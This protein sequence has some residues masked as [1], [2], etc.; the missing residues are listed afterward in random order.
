MGPRWIFTPLTPNGSPHEDQE[1]EVEQGDFRVMPVIH[2]IDEAPP[3][4]D[5]V[6][7]DWLVSRHQAN[8]ERAYRRDIDAWFDW[9]DTHGVE[10]FSARRKHVDLYLALLER[11][12]LANSTQCRM[13]S[14]V[15][16]F[17]EYARDDWDELVNPAAK[18]KRPP[19]GELSMTPYLD[20]GELSRVLAAADARSPMDAALARML[21]YTGARVAELCGASTSDLQAEMG[22]T[23]LLVRRKGGRPERLTVA[24]IAAEA[25]RRH[26]DGR[27]GPLFLD[28]YGERMRPYQ[29]TYRVRTL[30]E[31]AGVKTVSPHGLRHTMA[32]LMLRKT[33]DP[34]RV[35]R[36]LSHRRVSTTMRYLRQEDELEGSPVHALAGMIEPGETP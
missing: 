26:L 36:L 5:S 29:V 19:V 1:I 15:S 22:A 23:T 21:A 33:A 35:Q 11:R 30:C 17:Y 3:D 31:A 4:R 6:A 24:R 25:L 34:Q 9:C 12:G 7:A 28:A 14:A 27:V 13:L 18:V 2:K 10:V 32:T 20:A 16:S 8:T